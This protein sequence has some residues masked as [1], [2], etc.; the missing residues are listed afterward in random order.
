MDVE[1]MKYL[2]NKNKHHQRNIDAE[3]MRYIIKCSEKGYGE[4]PLICDALLEGLSKRQLEY[5]R[6][7][8]NND[9]YLSLRI[10][11]IIVTKFGENKLKNAP[12]PKVIEVFEDKGSK[13]V[14]KARNVLKSRYDYQTKKVQKLTLRAMLNA[15]KIDREWGYYRL[16][17]SWDEG[18]RKKILELWEQYHEALCARVIIT[19]FPKNYV[20]QHYDEL[21]K[22]NNYKYLCFRLAGDKSFP[23]EYDRLKAIEYL[24]IIKETGREVSDKDLEKALYGLA[25]DICNHSYPYEVARWEDVSV[26]RV[27]ATSFKL[28]RWGFFI[29]GSMGRLDLMQRFKEWDDSIGQVVKE[30]TLELFPD[31]IRE[32][33]GNYRDKEV[34]S[35]IAYNVIRE[36]FPN[37]YAS[38]LNWEENTNIFV[39]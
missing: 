26:A 39:L 5:V 11:E 32:R 29:L 7:Q 8:T 23:L 9:Y 20:V 2:H 30:K 36:R 21:E 18:F 38:M 17:K 31:W 34:I 15:S 12:I 1:V 3:I 24:Q 6:S 28:V 4:L 27:S 14:V 22:G 35:Q 13:L 37:E 25:A 19:Y 33:D 10:K 16:I